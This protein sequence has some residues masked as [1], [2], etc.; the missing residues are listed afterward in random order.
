MRQFFQ[1]YLFLIN[2]FKQDKLILYKI[3]LKYK[4]INR[5]LLA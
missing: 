1:N 4:N 2:D 3:Y 5:I